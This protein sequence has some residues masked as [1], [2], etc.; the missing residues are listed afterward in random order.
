M[1]E[2]FG[3]LTEIHEGFSS[4]RKFRA[5][6][7]LLRLFSLAELA[8]K[9]RECEV[10]RKMPSLGVRCSDVVELGQ[11]DDGTGFLL[12]S[13]LPGEDA[14]KALPRLAEHEQFRVGE[15]AGREL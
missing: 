12:L 5:G 2:R 14:G 7:K 10:L 15:A 8:A 13:F 11:L 9:E 4:D 3:P 6:D 1:L